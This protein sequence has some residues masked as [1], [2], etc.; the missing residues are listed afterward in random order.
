MDAATGKQSSGTLSGL[1]G[2]AVFSG[3][4]PA[5]RIAESGFPPLFLT[6]ARASIA[7]LLGL[8]LLAALRQARPDRQALG[9]LLIVALGVVVGYPLLSACALQHIESVRSAMWTGLLP[10]STAFFAVIRNGERPSPL[11]WLLS[12]CGAAAVAAYALTQTH[13]GSLIGDGLMLAAV[14]VCGLGYAEGASLSRKLGG[15]QVISWALGL[16]SPAMIVL[17]LVTRPPGWENVSGAAWCSL[18]YVALFSMMLGFVFWY[19]GLAQGG[20]AR[21]G[22][23]QLLQPFGGLALSA[24]LLHEAVPPLMIGVTLVVLACVFGARRAA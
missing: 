2:I 5:T 4:L 19:H 14:L 1:I 20:V 23:L 15:W 11:F 22:Q 18:A 16:A 8:A 6:A 7:A 24:W 12:L 17:A 10:L 9:P 3:S 21:I 13:G